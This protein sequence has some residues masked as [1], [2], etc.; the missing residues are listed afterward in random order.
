MRSLGKAIP[1]II[2]FEGFFTCMNY[3]VLT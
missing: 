1:T 3:L 2:T